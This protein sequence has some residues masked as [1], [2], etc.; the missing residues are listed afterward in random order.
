ME[1][2]NTYIKNLRI[3]GL[4]VKRAEIMIQT[5][6]QLHGIIFIALCCSV[7]HSAIYIPNV[8]FSYFYYPSIRYV[9]F[10]ATKS[11]AV[12]CVF[13]VCEFT[14][15]FVIDRME[16]YVKKVLMHDIAKIK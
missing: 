10:Q 8:V 16:S 11:L 14:A 9:E 7:V 2:L 15:G 6:I 12:T 13:A 3:P 4:T 1:R 5:M